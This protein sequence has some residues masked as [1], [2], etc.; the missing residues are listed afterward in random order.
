MEVLI[1]ISYVDYSP[2]TKSL[3]IFFSGCNPPYCNGCC[4]PELIDF[5]NGEHWE[6]IIL[7]IYDYINNYKDLIENVFLVGGSPTHQNQKE[8]VNFLEE[9]FMLCGKNIWLFAREE[10]EDIP[11]MFKDYCSYIKCGTYIPELLCYNNIQYG[12]NLATSNQNI[13]KKDKDY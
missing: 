5:N 6:I 8:M 10:L 13:Y 4:N 12:I 3:D 1:N 7:K 11:K 2:Q 9:I